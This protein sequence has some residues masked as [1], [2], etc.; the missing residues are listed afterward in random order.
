MP[1]TYSHYRFGAECIGVMPEELQKIVNEHRDLF[2]IGVHGPDIFFYD[3][4]HDNIVS[5]GDKMHFQ[6]ARPFFENCIKVYHENEEKDE[7]M[8]YILGFLTHFTFDSQAH[9]YVDR[10]AE[11]S[12][13][14]HNLVESQYDG[15][16][17]RK[18]G[19]KVNLVDRSES[20]KPSKEAA[21]IIALFFPF[22]ERIMYR[23][24]KCH[25]R[26]INTLN[27]VSNFKFKFTNFCL[28]LTKG[29]GKK[30]LP[31]SREELAICKDSNLRLEKLQ[32]KALK[33]YPKLL[34]DFLKA[35]HGEKKLMRY[36]NHDFSPWPDYKEIPVLSYEEELNYKI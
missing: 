32:K 35:L 1:T 11:V 10:K 24:C 15:Y 17:M 30:D 6:E 16:L 21:R 13:I 23:V 3:L 19:R 26:V 9:G 31:V 29:D 36:F 5:Y 7:M 18:E 4:L 20:L 28:K 33:L 34:N 12:G 2:D 25:K 14:T 22:D 8:A 27:C